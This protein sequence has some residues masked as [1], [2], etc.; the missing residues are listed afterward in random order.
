MQGRRRPQPSATN[1]PSSS[2]PSSPST[3]GRCGAYLERSLLGV[4]LGALCGPQG[5]EEESPLEN[6][7]CWPAAMAGEAHPVPSRTRK[8]SPLAPM[9]L[10]RKSVGEQGAAVHQGAFS[11]TCTGRRGPRADTHAGASFLCARAGPAGSGGLRASAPAFA[12]PLGFGRLPNYGFRSNPS[13]VQCCRCMSRNISR[14]GEWIC[15]Y[16]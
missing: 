2:P 8:L 10:R 12:A 6:A 3:R 14:L 7:P 5:T 15:L 4:V 1:R 13:C 16:Y 9:V 11:S